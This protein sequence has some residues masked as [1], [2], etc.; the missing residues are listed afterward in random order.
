M[1]ATVQETVEKTC[2]NCRNFELG[3]PFCSEWNKQRRCFLKR[4]GYK[5]NSKHCKFWTYKP[6][7]LWET[8]P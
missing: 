5:W 8:Q 6:K 1:T 2:K 3:L 7:G 4:H